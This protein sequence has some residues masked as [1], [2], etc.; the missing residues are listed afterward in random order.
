M[1]RS[2]TLSCFKDSEFVVVGTAKAGNGHSFLDQQIELCL[3][4]LLLCRTMALVRKLITRQ[5]ITMS[6][7]C[8]WFLL[9]LSSWW[10]R[11]DM[12]LRQTR[13][14]LKDK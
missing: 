13:S 9:S 11:A 1:H 4:H 2:T 10:Q 7:S 12:T 6:R 5:N 14:P 8:M 3:R